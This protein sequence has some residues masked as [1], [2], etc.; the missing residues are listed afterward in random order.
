MEHFVYLSYNENLRSISRRLRGR[1]TD[2]EK[3][4]WSKVRRKQI[5]NH[6]FFRQKPLGGFIVDFYCKEARLVIEID[7]GQHYEDENIKADREREEFL[8]S[9]GLKILR[10]TN[11][12]VLKNI[13][14]VTAKI[15]GELN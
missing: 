5:K 2:A 8:K 10:F 12:E 13:D 11:L 7:G 3:L 9:L 14:G 15:Y 1:L 4:L 6:Q